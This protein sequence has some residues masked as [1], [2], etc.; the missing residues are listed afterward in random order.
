MSK[1][2]VSSSPHI[3]DKDTAS[4]IMRDVIIALIPATI[5]G[6]VIFGFYSLIVIAVCVGS[7]L[8]SEYFYNYFLKKPQTIKDLSAVVTGIL[9]GLNLPPLVPLYVPVIGSVFAI[10]IVKM[11]FGGIGK[12]FANPAITA[13]I[14][15]ILSFGTLMTHFI[16]PVDYSQGFFKGFFGKFSM[17]DA[18]ASSTPL[19]DG[20]FNLLDLF[21][22]TTEGCI[23]ETS[24]V[25]LLIGGI[26]LCVRRVIDFRLPLVIFAVM[27]AFSFI[28]SGDIA[29]V[30]PSLLSGGLI[31][32]AIF[33]ATD[34]ATSPNTVRGLMIYGL[35]IGIVNSILREFSPMAEGMSYAI[36]LGNIVTPIIDKYIYPKKFGEIR[37]ND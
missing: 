27:A 1:L 13:R 14:F 16:S 32:G 15:L 11:L 2:K 35:F 26:Y 33:M 7:C 9:L 20:D 18:V 19:T 8:L 21:I 29:S 17:T 3:N 10:I 23:G 28:F 4:G 30:L 31:L 5:A 37:Q 25:A 22:G 12:N 6:T 34:Y 36:L 24:A